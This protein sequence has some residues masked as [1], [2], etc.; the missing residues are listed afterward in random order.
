[1]NHAIP[2]EPLQPDGP[3]ESSLR[4]LARR[5]A[6]HAAVRWL[7]WRAP[8]RA[9]STDWCARNLAVIGFMNSANG[10]GAAARGLVEATTPWNPQPVCIAPFARTPPVPDGSAAIPWHMDHDHGFDL[11]VHVYNPDIFLA[12]VRRYGARILENHRFNLAVVNWETD[13]LPATW[14]HVLSLYHALA[15]PSSFTAAAVQRA[16]GREVHV[17]PNCVPVKPPRERA[18]ADRHFEFLC[19]FDHHSDVE[20]KNPLAA[21][22]AFRQACI[23]LPQGMTA[24]LRL[25]CHGNTPDALADR[26]RGEAPDVGVEI[27]RATLSTHDMERLWNET[28]CLVSLHRSEGFGLPVAEALARGIPVVAT[29]QGGILD[30]TNDESCSLVPGTP[31]VKNA[32]PVASAG[33]REWSGWIDPDI[34]TAAAALRHTITHYPEAVS[35]AA[36]GRRRLEATTSLSAVRRAFLTALRK[37]HVSVVNHPHAE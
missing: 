10:L 24:R 31:A 8:S 28:D 22:R 13:S 21:I 19:L 2:R 29:R 4:R 5:V 9:T 20:R 17:L 32:S 18:R 35:R 27:L 25:K 26:L 15:A 34:E 30:F 14:P 12:L 1:M 37:E 6:V 36:S 33:Y 23:D 3:R 7:G 16:T 11:G